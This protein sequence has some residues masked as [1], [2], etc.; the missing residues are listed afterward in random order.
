MNGVI[1]VLFALSQGV[2]RADCVLTVANNALVI[3]NGAVTAAPITFGANFGNNALTTTLTQAAPG[4]SAVLNIG[5]L[6]TIPNL[7]NIILNAGGTV[8]VLLT[9]T[10]GVFN[11]NPINLVGTLNAGV[12]SF[13]STEFLYTNLQANICA[14]FSVAVNQISLAALLNGSALTANLNLVA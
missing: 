1:S 9:T 2:A 6:G 11:P 4:T 12:L 13:A 3:T 14:T 5:G 7:T 8:N 10:A